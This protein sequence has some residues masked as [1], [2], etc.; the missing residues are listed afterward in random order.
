MFTA[1]GNY[2][3]HVQLNNDYLELGTEEEARVGR[4][5]SQSVPR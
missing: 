3:R 1:L 4:D 5:S 2:A